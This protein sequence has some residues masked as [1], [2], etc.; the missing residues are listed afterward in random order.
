VYRSVMKTLAPLLALSIPLLTSS[1]ASSAVDNKV[2]TLW[3]FKSAGT[4]Q[5]SGQHVELSRFA[6]QLHSGG[7][8]IVSSSCGTDGGIYPAACGFPD[9]RIAAFEISTNDAES[10]TK[11]GFIPLGQ[12]RE[13][14]VGSCH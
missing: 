5:C 1:C 11:I 9:G 3:V 14:K 13:A 10:A 8:G 12:A 6:E 7:V 4:T 2:T